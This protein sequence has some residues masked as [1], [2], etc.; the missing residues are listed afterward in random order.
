MAEDKQ[1]SVDTVGLLGLGL[2][3]R[4]IAACLLCHG[5]NVIAYNRTPARAE[6]SRAFLAG[7]MEEV[8]RRGLFI[9]EEVADWAERFA[10]VDTV[11]G[12]ADCPFVVE[13]VKEDLG[14]KRRL[15]A[16]LETHVAPDAVIAS[17]TSSFP[18][19]LL[20]A[21][22]M[23]PERFVVMHWAEPTWITR[24]MEIVRNERTS[25]EAVARTRD[26]GLRCDK[27][28][29]FLNFDI[30]GFIANRLMYAFIREAC[31]LYDLGVADAATIDRS[32]RNDTGWWSA[33]AGPFRWM[34]LTGLE[35]YG[36]VMD[37]LLPELCNRKTVPEIMKKMLAE[38]AE[39]TANCKGFY[40][41][42]EHTARAW[43]QTWVEFTYDVRDLIRKHESR[44]RD[45]GALQE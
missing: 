21:E 13:S 22:S 30:R 31:Y 6:K 1:V 38:G 16:E 41:Y 8:V 12:L 36:L 37:G 3:G 5:L 17:N 24:F 11:S 15:Y 4:G 35:A 14:V 45:A 32:F 25:E 7:V 20:Q 43:E 34:D 9:S 39:G 29:S 28:P 33:L 18:L 10:V 27:Q 40:P 23:H 42:D 19:T 44:L 26:L 2:M